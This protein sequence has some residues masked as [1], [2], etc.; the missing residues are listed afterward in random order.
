MAR[1]RV[2]RG[3]RETRRRGF[4]TVFCFN[5]TLPKLGDEPKQSK[6]VRSSAISTSTPLERLGC[7]AAERKVSLKK[8]KVIFL[9]KNGFG[10]RWSFISGRR[11]PV[12]LLEK[13]E[14][15]KLG[16]GGEDISSSQGVDL[17]TQYFVFCGQRFF[18][19]FA[20]GNAIIQ[21]V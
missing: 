13:D 3:W 2:T 9:S 20:K 1:G 8:P 6:L 16:P 15:W 11:R 21:F 4:W 17:T 14:S 12:A 7:S 5:R 18:F 10:A 19:F